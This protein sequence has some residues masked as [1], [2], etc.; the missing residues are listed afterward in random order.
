[1]AVGGCVLRDLE[2][3]RR[4]RIDHLLC[5][6]HDCRFHAAVSAFPG[7]TPLGRRDSLTRRPC[8]R[9]RVG[10]AS[11]D[12]HVCACQ[13]A[14]M[15][16][17][18]RAGAATSSDL[19][20]ASVSSLAQSACWVCR[21][22]STA[23]RLWSRTCL[24]GG[25]RRHEL[26]GSTALLVEHGVGFDSMRG[27]GGSQSQRRAALS[28]SSGCSAF[29]SDALVHHRVV[30]SRFSSSPVP[31]GLPDLAGPPV[32]PR[33]LPVPSKGASACASPFDVSRSPGRG[34]PHSPSG[35]ASYASD[36]LCFPWRFIFIAV[37][38]GPAG[39]IGSPITVRVPWRRPGAD[40]GVCLNSMGS[41]RSQP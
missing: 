24:G 38:M 4:G 7:K 11:A 30:H 32:G 8:R 25:C 12:V 17:R 5:T 3:Q 6:C 2:T 21:G 39:V 9:A 33:Q 34:A 26:A 31:A 28:L 19:D 20:T 35:V 16:A 10:C 1:M 40:G 15:A 14:V 23:R 36:R 37:F 13:P 22:S 27:A 18:S 29:G 41:P